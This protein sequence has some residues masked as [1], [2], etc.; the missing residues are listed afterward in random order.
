MPTQRELENLLVDFDDNKIKPNNFIYLQAILIGVIFI[1][2]LFVFNAISYSLANFQIDIYI[3]LAVLI[4]II[5]PLIGLY[6]FTKLHRYG[7]YISIHYLFTSV[8][9]WLIIIFESFYKV[10]NKVQLFSIPRVAYSI[11]VVILGLIFIIYTLRDRY[12]AI[13]DL[14]RSAIFL[15]ILLSLFSPVIF[16]IIMAFLVK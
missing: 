13:Y 4:I 3:I 11:L 7:W 9:F 8:F 5:Y 14:T 16:A 15:V 12:L 10:E 2:G 1:H 6:G